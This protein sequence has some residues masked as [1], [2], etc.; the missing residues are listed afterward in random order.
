MTFNTKKLRLADCSKEGLI[1][2]ADPS[3]ANNL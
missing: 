3:S 2:F 1:N